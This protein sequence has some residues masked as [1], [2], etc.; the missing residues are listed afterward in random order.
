MIKI[1]KN[2]RSSKPLWQIALAVL[3]ILMSIYFIKNEHLEVA[4]IKSTLQQVDG[5][6]LILGL[7]VTGLYFI[8]QAL[9][10]VFSFR[11]AGVKVGVQ[12]TLPLYLKRNLISIFLPAGGFSSLMFFTRPLTQK[13][14]NNSEIHYSSY[15]Y[16]L[17]GILSVIVVAMPLLIMMLLRNKLTSAELIPFLIILVLIVLV[18]YLVWSFVKRKVVYRLIHRMNPKILV[19][20]DDILSTELNVK[21]FIFTLLISVGIEFIGVAHVYIS[22][23]ALGFHPDIFISFVA[24]IVMVMLL[25]VSPF[26]RGIGAIEVSMTYIFVKSGIP[27]PQAAAITLLFRFFEFWIPL[28]FGAGSFLFSKK[29]IV[30]RVLPVFIIFISGVIDIVSA[31][32]PALPGRIRVLEK[33]L[34]QAAL[35]ISNFFVFFTGL[36]L[37]ILS[38]YLLKGV[39]RAWRITVFLLV[40]T[41]IAHLVKGIDYEEASVSI[42]ALISLLF[43]Y[44]LYNVKA[45]PVYR[46]NWWKIWILG[47]L[48]LVLSAVGGTYFLEK[49]HMGMDYSFVESIQASFRLIFLFDASGYLPQSSFGHFFVLFIYVFSI[50]LLISAILFSLHPIFFTDSAEEEKDN[51]HARLLVQNYGN[52]ALDY[53]KYYPDKL[54]YF[55]NDG[56][57]AYKIQ[58]SYAVVLELPVCSNQEAV[59]LI[60]EDFEKYCYGNGLRT[61]Y[62][63]VPESSVEMFRKLKKKVLF[64]GQEAILDLDTF[65]LSGSKM[66]PLR[67]AINK[68]KKM[69]YTFHI[70]SPEIKDGVLQKLQ[71]VS[72][73]WLKTPGKSEQVFSQGM[74]IPEMVEK[75]TVM[76]IENEE[77]K[78]VAFLNIIPDYVKGEG[79][80]DMIRM[81]DDAPTGIVYFLLTEMF[82][83]MK[84]QGLSKVNLGMV[85][86][87]GIEEAKTVTEKSMKFALEK[88]RSL[89]HFKGQF[90]FKDKF[91]PVWVKKYLVYDMD[92]D[93]VQ[94]PAVLKGVSKP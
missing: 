15:I 40:L 69:G 65:S 59:L 33:L 4:Q 93:L 28:L 53:F 30:L 10:Y 13:G 43:T 79:T 70:Y 91:D 54:L 31:M 78:I 39:R 11:T 86:F 48:V 74:F 22:M 77:E 26:L 29:S 82:S 20:I 3:M 51:S 35:N 66:H 8:F 89:Q 56:F 24:Y 19:F 84:E 23:V 58:G 44:R 62:Y 9:M 7:A 68:A 67:N 55:S 32:L 92:Y 41:C 63:R 60:I 61:F 42:L 25:I 72:N 88:L 94:F 2:R 76:T 6:Y 49:A 46:Q 64:I 16:G 71:H 1:L 81:T 83:W 38:V 87:A 90:Q 37:I 36:L 18:L 14:I 73:E 45:M 17:I 47:L 50:I 75:T 57:L 12:T 80:Y 34:P 27:A 21:H 85:A 52:S 5:F